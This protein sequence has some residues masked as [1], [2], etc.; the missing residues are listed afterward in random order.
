[1]ARQFNFKNFTHKAFVEYVMEKMHL[2]DATPEVKEKIQKQILMLLGDR[3]L[4]SIM[5]AMKDENLAEFNL[6]KEAHPEMSEFEILYSIIEHVPFLHEVLIKNVNGL[7]DELT[8]D[9]ERIEKIIED[10]KKAK[11]K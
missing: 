8:Y 1:M 4:L 6:S 5:G 3:I 9:A 7:A 10:N 2:D 11:T